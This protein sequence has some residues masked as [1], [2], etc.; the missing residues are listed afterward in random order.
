MTW[1]MDGNSDCD[2]PVSEGRKTLSVEGKT[3]IRRTTVWTLESG[4]LKQGLFEQCGD[5]EPL[6]RFMQMLSVFV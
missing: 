3:D 2:K 4:V 5:L 6:H 1:V